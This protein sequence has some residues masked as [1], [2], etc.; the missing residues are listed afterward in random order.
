MKNSLEV[1]EKVREAVS[2]DE[3]TLLLE[4]S[5]FER[6]PFV[7]RVVVQGEG[8]GLNF[9]LKH[10]SDDPLIEYYD[11]RY[12]HTPYGQFVSRYYLSTL[13]ESLNKHDEGA[14]AGGLLLD[15]GVSDWQLDHARFSESVK[16]AVDRLGLGCGHEKAAFEE[17]VPMQIAPDAARALM[18]LIDAIDRPRPDDF[19]DEVCCARDALPEELVSKLREIVT[20]NESSPR[21]R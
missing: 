8:Y 12:P 21:C 20:A 2:A 16:W 15:G 10:D 1:S 4:A 9:K 18:Q 3:N 17:S 6:V 19:V 13:M 11:A 5:G 7:C 14:R